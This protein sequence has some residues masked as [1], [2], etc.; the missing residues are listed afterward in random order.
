MSIR[1]KVFN[2]LKNANENGYYFMHADD[3]AEDLILYD[4]ELEIY[5]T[6]ELLP[7]IREWLCE[8]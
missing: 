4:A 7:Y 3:I 2:A 1:E 5:S 8:D 6:W